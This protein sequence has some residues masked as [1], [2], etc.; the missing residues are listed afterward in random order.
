[1]IKYIYV[2]LPPLTLF[3]HDGDY[4]NY[5]LDASIDE[6]VH[7]L[8]TFS[9]ESKATHMI[10]LFYSHCVGITFSSLSWQALQ[11]HL[12]ISRCGRRVNITESRRTLPYDFLFIV[13][14]RQ[15]SIVNYIRWQSH[16]IFEQK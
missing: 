15:F 16:S 8:D 14:K 10:D 13:L 7:F 11:S 5:P 4:E 1:M 6:I 3:A 9:F 12:S 2:S